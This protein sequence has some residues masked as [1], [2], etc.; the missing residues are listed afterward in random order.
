[1]K[2][3]PHCS[4]QLEDEDVRCGN[5]SG[6][7]VPNRKGKGKKGPSGK[8]GLKR[9]LLFLALGALAWVV[10]TMPD[11]IPDPR[12]ILNQEPSRGTILATMKSD[13]ERLQT[14]QEAYFRDHGEYSGKP[15]DLAFSPSEKV[16]VSIIAT[17]SGWSGA[18]TYQEF[19]PDFGC[20]VFE[21]SVQPPPTPTVPP[22]PGEIACSEGSE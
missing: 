10:W 1:M 15:A 11:G 8:R 5:C 12:G 18:S 9:V 7:V 21:G 13:L 3:C 22:G 17:P 14:L 20:A 2:L 6:W 19:L 4:H 16:I